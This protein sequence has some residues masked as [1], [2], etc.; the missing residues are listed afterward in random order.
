VT[1]EDMTEFEVKNAEISH[2]LMDPGAS[3]RSFI[4]P[5]T[6]IGPINV[7][8]LDEDEDEDEDEDDDEVPELV[9]DSDSDS[10]DEPNGG[11]WLAAN[12][13]ESR[14]V[15]RPTQHGDFVLA[16]GTR[17][18]AGNNPIIANSLLLSGTMRTL[19]RGDM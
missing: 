11:V 16:S 3:T 7:L 8:D 15:R 12:E 13:F 14:I 18:N 6:Y 5:E 19:D 17:I 4:D 10:D 2:V 1:D 9:P